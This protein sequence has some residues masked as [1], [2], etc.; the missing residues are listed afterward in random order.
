MGTAVL[1]LLVMAGAATVIA[2]KSTNAQTPGPTTP[3][4]THGSNEDPAHEANESPEHEAAENDGT[5][6]GGPG[7]KL[8]SNE[9]KTHEAGE[10]AEREAQ[11]DA[12]GGQPAAP[13]SSSGTT[14]PAN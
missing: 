2:T 7:G 1:S 13:S 8:G 10:S 4:A 12:N 6:R 14:S 3:S 11:E 9:D 5:F